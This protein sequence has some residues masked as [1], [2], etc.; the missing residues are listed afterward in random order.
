MELNGEL[1]GGRRGDVG[2]EDEYALELAQL[3]LLLLR[4]VWL[5]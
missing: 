2:G 4:L 1:E 3:W 5:R